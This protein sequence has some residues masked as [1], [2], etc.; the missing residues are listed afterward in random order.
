MTDEEGTLAS[1]YSYGKVLNPVI[2]AWGPVNL[3]DQW[4]NTYGFP[5]TTY[6]IQEKNTIHVPI[7]A[8]RFYTFIASKI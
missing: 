1:C 2:R 7:L 4:A 3:R 6:H 8:K 5:K